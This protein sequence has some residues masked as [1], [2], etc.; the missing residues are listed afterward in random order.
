VSRSGFYGALEGDREFARAVAEARLDGVDQLEDK[1]LARAEDK[2]DRLAMFLLDRWRY[3]ATPARD[4][5]ETLFSPEAA[6]L[7]LGTSLAPFAQALDE[8]LREFY[9]RQ[10]PR[11]VIDQ[12]PQLPPPEPP[13]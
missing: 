6:A 8:V 11:E 12:P 2:S 10:P 5:P 13:R 7:A 3:R 1:V 4:R 9:Q